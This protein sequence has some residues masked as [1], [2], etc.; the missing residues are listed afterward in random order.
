MRFEGKRE[1]KCDTEEK[2]KKGG[3]SMYIKPF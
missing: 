3:K 1:Q 2:S